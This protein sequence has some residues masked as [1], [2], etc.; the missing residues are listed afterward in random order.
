MNTVD[1]CWRRDRHWAADR[2]RLARCAVGF[3]APMHHNVGRGLRRYTVTDPS[4]DPVSPR[5]GTLRYGATVLPGKVWITFQGSMQIKLVRPL[6]VK[7]FTTIDG[8]GA[9]VHVAYGAGILL[10]QVSN[11]IVHGIQV[12]HIRAQAAGPVMDPLGELI[13]M[14]GEDGDAIRLVSS[15][16]VW[17]DHT[18]LYSCEDGLL[19]VTHGSNAVTVSN[20]WF[21]EHD[22][23][24]LLGHNDDFVQDKTM[25]V[26]VAFN[27]FG[28]NCNQRMPRIRYGYAH[29]ANNLYDGW[30]EYA[31]GGSTHPIIL[32]QGNLYVATPG[33][34][35]K[36]TLRMD[37]G[38]VRAM[39]ASWKWRS[40]NDAFVN[41]AFFR[42]TGTG[43]VRPPYGR[44]QRFRVARAKAVRALTRDAGALGCSASNGVRC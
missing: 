13:E 34:T 6:L 12:H 19:D 1:R 35:K 42:Q 2:Q 40:V 9:D 37:A 23:V 8:R 22:K 31:V 10:Y 36:A 20:T 30:L 33:G 18:T 15:S 4:D 5:P 39:S 25:Q 27:R 11:V 28:P 7:N 16:K 44:K 24:M 38:G 32:S 17:V 41:G 3:A 26:T 14:G 29:L 21:R 43:P